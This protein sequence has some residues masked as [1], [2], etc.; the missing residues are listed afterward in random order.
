MSLKAVTV[1]T[2]EP[3]FSLLTE[4]YN[5]KY[6]AKPQ[7]YTYGVEVELELQTNRIGGFFQHNIP[8]WDKHEDGSL[9]NG[10]ELVSSEPVGIDKI[11]D[12]LDELKKYISKWP[13]I[14]GANR[15]SVH[16]HINCLNYTPY[17][18][19]S[20]YAK[21][22][23]FEPALIR[24]SG[25]S[26][27]GNLFCLSSKDAKYAF[28]HVCTLLS[29]NGPVRSMFGGN[30][31][32]TAINLVSIA[33]Y[34]T[35]EVRCMRG[36]SDTQLIKDWVHIL[37]NIVE[38]PYNPRDLPG[39][40]SGDGWDKLA[41]NIL[42]PHYYNILQPTESEMFEGMR[43]VQELAWSL[44]GEWT[45]LG[46]IILDDPITK[47]RWSHKTQIIPP[48][49]Q[50][51]QPQVVVAEGELQAEVNFNRR[52]EQAVAQMRAQRDALNNA[53][54]RGPRIIFNPAR[55]IQPGEVE[56]V[57]RDPDDVEDNF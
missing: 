3:I 57:Q 19:L 45:N 10:I 7:E 25:E 56:W 53:Q 9:R 8:G 31:R 23:M 5:R 13:I 54:Q 28:N 18:V 50:E 52:I 20:R 12:H 48:D 41:R 29:R 34:G 21:L 30:F 47:T 22:L 1:A 26:R 35:I 46:P 2:K 27:K 16:V 36:T 39:L 6:A 15:T 17:G 33:K 14:E 11:G 4:G 32:Y 43:H 40:F 55:P 38:S 44:D 51:V 42:G 37:H 24:F 49:L